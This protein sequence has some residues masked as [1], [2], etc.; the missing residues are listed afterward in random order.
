M[1]EICNTVVIHQQ[2]YI[3]GFPMHTTYLRIPYENL[4]VGQSLKSLSIIDSSQAQ[5]HMDPKILTYPSTVLDV[6][7]NFSSKIDKILV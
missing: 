1:F 7:L 3:D 5:R 2:T 4:L 6:E